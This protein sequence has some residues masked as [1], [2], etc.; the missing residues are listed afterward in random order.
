[1]RMVGTESDESWLLNFLI[2][3]PVG[4]RPF[5]SSLTKEV[6]LPFHLDQR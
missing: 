5:R 4:S 1:M 6:M 2:S 3:G